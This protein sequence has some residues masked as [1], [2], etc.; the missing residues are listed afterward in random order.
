MEARCGPPIVRRSVRAYVGAS[1]PLLLRHRSRL[2][3]KI[4]SLP[5]VVVGWTAI[6]EWLQ[7]SHHCPRILRQLILYSRVCGQ[8]L[9]EFGMAVDE[10][11]VVGQLRILREPLSNFRVPHKELTEVL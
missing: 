4:D 3:I 9:L 5:R 11:L 1:V 8:V 6:V 10:L 7:P 2:R